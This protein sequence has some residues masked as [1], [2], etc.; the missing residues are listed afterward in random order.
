MSTHTRR[1]LESYLRP[2]HEQRLRHE[3]ASCAPRLPALEAPEGDCHT[4]TARL[5]CERGAR[6]LRDQKAESCPALGQ[7]FRTWNAYAKP[8]FPVEFLA[9]VGC[10]GNP[11]LSL[12]SCVPVLGDRKKC[13]KKRSN[14]T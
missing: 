10:R 3:N 8:L 12:S 7:D 5:V 9:I 4:D 6:A 1:A 13:Q 2:L 14:E 11:T